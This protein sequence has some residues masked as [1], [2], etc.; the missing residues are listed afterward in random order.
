MEATTIKNAIVR[1]NHIKNACWENA[2]CEFYGDTLM[3]ERTRK[4]ITVDSIVEITGRKD[5]YEGG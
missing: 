1:G 4:R 5:F 3:S 2:L